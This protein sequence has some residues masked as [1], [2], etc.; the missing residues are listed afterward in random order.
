MRAVRRHPECDRVREWASLELDGELS[1]FERVLLDAH[2]SVCAECREFASSTAAFTAGLRAAEF[3]RPER[4]VVV[5]KRRRTAAFGR[6]P[7]AAALAA[8]AVGLGSLLTSSELRNIT[9]SPAWQRPVA[10]DFE[11]TNLIRR[12]GQQRKATLGAR[13]AGRAPTRPHQFRGGPVV[14]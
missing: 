10:A 4:P 13:Q 2:L 3:E 6:V 7:A 8:V 11:A 1:D 9:E 14:H 12:A 5:R